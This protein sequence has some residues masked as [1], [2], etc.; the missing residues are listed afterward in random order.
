[1]G[2]NIYNFDEK[3]FMIGVGIT[4]L[5]VMTHEELNSDEII[6][7]SQD[8]NREWIS[9]LVTICMIASINIFYFNLLGRMRRSKR[10]LDK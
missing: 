5:W 3:R 10:Y 6:G 8:G 7:V 4:L 9:L 1:M 2:E